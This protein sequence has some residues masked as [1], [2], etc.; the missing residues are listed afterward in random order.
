MRMGAQP[1]RERVEGKEL[2]AAIEAL[3]AS[4]SI[5]YKRS[6]PPK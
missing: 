3:P 2:M 1:R 4:C 5:K 6:R